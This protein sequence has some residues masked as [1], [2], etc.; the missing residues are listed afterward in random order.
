M[1]ELPH[2]IIKYLLEKKPQT[3]DQLS[4]FVRRKAGE[5]KQPPVAK[6]KLIKAYRELIEAGEIQPDKTLAMLI[7][8]RAVRTASGV[9]P[10][11]IMTA[12]LGCPSNCIYCPT[13]RNMPKSYLSNQP[14]AMRAVLSHF[15]PYKQMMVR[16][17]AYH[18]NGHT[19][20]KIEIIIIGG[21][22]SAHPP[23]YQAEF[24]YQI[25]KAA[26]EYST[27][28]PVEKHNIHD[29]QAANRI[30]KAL[31]EFNIQDKKDILGQ[32]DTEAMARVYEQQTI[33]ETATNRIIGITVETRPDY[34][35][36]DELVRMRKLGV[37][38]IEI[39]VQHINDEVLIKN[40]RGHLTK[41]VIKATQL[42]KDAGFKVAYHIMPGMYGSDFKKD[43]QVFK[44]LFSKPEFQPD[45]LKI[46]P[47][48]VVEQSDLYDLFK[49]GKYK[50]LDNEDLIKLMVEIK[51][52]IPYYTRIAR[53]FRDIPS[54]SIKGGHKTINL[55]E[56]IH[57]ELKNQNIACHCIRCRE[58]MRQ[59][60]LNSDIEYNQI[61]I[62]ALGA[63]EY[64]LSFD[65]QDKSTIYAFLRLRLPHFN[66]QQTDP[67]GKTLPDYL[68]DLNDAAI[69]R[70][71]HTYGKM[72]P[73][74]QRETTAIQHAGLGKRLMTA[75]EQLAKKQGY[76]KIAVIAGIGVREYYKKLGYQLEDTYM[77]KD[78]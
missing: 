52:F 32:D 6:E 31:T 46:Y 47:C 50:P 78:L 53:L 5:T 17:R 45:F 48:V 77:V 21:T 67:N 20:D 69:V 12:P 71:I 22:W 61:E 56:L 64:F 41:A 18:D 33:N 30:T 19:T 62:P 35:T 54:D 28:M 68:P 24:I 37:T 4:V 51:K 11:T 72:L 16:L 58:P 40:R 10:I 15:D 60:T 23:Q 7:T 25:Y 13:E 43:V 63:N 70:E 38:K 1:Q 55:R 73:L 59:K 27:T 39:G 44:D 76:K 34:I 9:A 66:K 14:A 8:K 3:Q 29:G 75:A 36:M 65:S 26:N 74:E 49:A 2:Q 42:M 57:K